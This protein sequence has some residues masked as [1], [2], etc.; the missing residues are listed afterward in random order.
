MIRKSG[1]RF[2]EKITLKQKDSPDQRGVIHPPVR[3]RRNTPAIVHT[4]AEESDLPVNTRLPE[5]GRHQCWHELC[6]G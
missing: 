3:K 1:Y 2:S 6:M 5:H 4:R